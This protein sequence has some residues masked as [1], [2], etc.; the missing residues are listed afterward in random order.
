M[1]NIDNCIIAA[2]QTFDI[3]CRVIK[4]NEANGMSFYP[5]KKY[6]SRKND[7]NELRKDITCF[8]LHHS[9]TYTAKATYNGLIG[10]GLSVSF[11]IDDNDINGY[12]TIYQCLDIKDA[13]WSHGSFN[14]KGSGVEVSYMPQAW[15]NPNLYSEVNKK[16]WNVPEHE[17]VS[18][19][20]HGTTR[21][22][23]AP[24]A[25][26]IASCTALM[27]GY[28]TAFPDVKRGFPR[29]EKGE[30]IKTVVASPEGL[31]SHFNITQQKIDIAG[32]PFDDVEKEIKARFLA[33]F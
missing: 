14:S 27:W 24:T 10:R 4:W 8:V 20:V 28:C 9:V 18:D 15:E 17:I 30:V 25:A 19:T 6:T 16:K 12:A 13:G 23:F 29:D 3:G 5:S 22:V 7:I 11:I 31:I 21:K 26:Q 1:E 33:G 2:G 32:F